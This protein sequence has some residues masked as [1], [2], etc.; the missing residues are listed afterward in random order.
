MSPVLVSV[1]VLAVIFGVASWRNVNLGTLA[2]PG[3]LVVGALAGLNAEEVLAGFPVELFMVV[4]GITYLF[5]IAQ[6]NGTVDWLLECG[7]TLLRGRIV[8]LPLLL[9]LV[10]V[11]II[12]FDLDPGLLALS[13]GAVLMLGFASNED[14]TYVTK[15]AWPT[16]F[17]LAGVMTYV[18]VMQKV[19]TLKAVSDVL[20][21]LG[22]PV[23]A[24]LLLSMM[25]GLISVFASS[26]G[27][28][29]A[30]IPMLA[31]VLAA[32]PSLPLLGAV[33]TITASAYLVDANPFNLLGALVIG[34][35]RAEDQKSMFRKLVGWSAAMSV[36]APVVTWASLVLMG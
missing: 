28:M 29:A 30:T 36:V 25:T 9:F 10:A 20:T 33:A 3:A 26:V 11:G 5:A 12:V 17:M 8:F 27:T 16:C 19:G 18:A 22:G 2:F 23:V 31:P 15:V 35:A 7:V 34:N 32:D 1:L 14:R 6:S 21:G 4:V 24:V 13:I